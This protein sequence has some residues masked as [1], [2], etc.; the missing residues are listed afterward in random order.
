MFFIYLLLLKVLFIAFIFL[1]LF[2]AVRIS[3]RTAMVTPLSK[4]TE[5]GAWLQI[6]LPDKTVFTYPLSRRASV[7]RD[8]SNDLVL[9]DQTV[10]VKHCAIFKKSGN[11]YLE[12]L[13]SLN[14]TFVNRQKV[15]GTVLIKPG[16]QIKVGRTVMLL[17]ASS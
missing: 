13:N 16:D 9:P 3:Y 6:T 14:G 7:G 5:P 15:I 11:W 4:Q 8:A 17:K 2:W 12:D 1:F 10:S